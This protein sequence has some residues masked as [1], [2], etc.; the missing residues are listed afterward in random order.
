LELQKT[1][2]TKYKKVHGPQTYKKIAE[3]TGINISR[4]F[5]IFNGALMKINEY[6]IF[7]KKTHPKNESEGCSEVFINK[8]L[9]RIESKDIQYIKNLL[10]RKIRMNQ[11]IKNHIG[12]L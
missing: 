9:L 10:K 4:I 5:R 11:I 8:S 3:D 2:L 7:K 12:V 1:I 6:E